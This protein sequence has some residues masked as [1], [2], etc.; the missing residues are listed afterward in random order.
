MAKAT[1]EPTAK[2][3]GAAAVQDTVD[4]S[5]PSDWTVT[6]HGH[7]FDADD[8]VNMPPKGV[9]YLLAN[10]VSQ[11]I[12]DAG[13]ITKDL[14]QGKSDKE[15]ADFIAERR[16]KRANA[17]RGGEVGHRVVGTRG[18]TLERVMAEIA[19][20]RLKAHVVKVNEARRAKGVAPVALPKGDLRK[21]ALAKILELQGEDIRAAAEAQMAETKA[22]GD[23]LAAGLT[24]LGL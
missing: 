13:A 10:G 16:A 20:A 23:A 22:A 14:K 9:G 12:V 8:L 6:V 4:V 1:K 18:S 24:D 5:I 2:S 3:L 11:S 15:V 17:I 19:E 21:Q 7:T